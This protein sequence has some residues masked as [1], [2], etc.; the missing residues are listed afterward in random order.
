M[1]QRHVHLVETPSARPN[2]TP[3]SAEKDFFY[4]DYYKA[5]FKKTDK[6]TTEVYFYQGL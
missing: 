6:E 3:E 2:S 4:T 1:T 5:P